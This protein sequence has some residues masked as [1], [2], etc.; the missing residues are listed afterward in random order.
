MVKD[1]N[2]ESNSLKSSYTIARTLLESGDIDTFKAIFQII[3]KIPVLELLEMNEWELEDRIEDPGLFQL[4]H[5]H[6]ISELL[7]V[8]HEIL[9]EIALKGR[10]R[11]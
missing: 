9:F 11:I 4:G 10:P 1:M 6:K 7:E 3:P 2:D 5:F 8:D